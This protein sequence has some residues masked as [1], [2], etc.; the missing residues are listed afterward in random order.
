MLDVR[1]LERRWIKYKIKIYFP[2]IAGV[3]FISVLLI[4]LPII[5]VDTKKVT[6]PKKEPSLPIQTTTQASTATHS[7]EEPSTVLEPSMDF[8]KT[9]ESVVPQ[10]STPSLPNPPAAKP[11]TQNVP[12]TKVLNVPDSSTIKPP[13]KAPPSAV[14][15]PSDKQVTLNHNNESKLDIE[16]VER[17]FKETSNPNLGLF[18][19]RYYYDHGNYADA[20]NFALK[21]N[22]I[23]NKID[24][25]WIIFSKSLMKLGKAEQAKKTL[26]LYIG[27]S[28]S[29]S[30][31][32]LLD[33]IERGT[34]K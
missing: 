3:V 34:F 28:N 16:S 9:F 18:I 30:A 31:R 22:G 19:A 33:S 5:L 32:A 14:V 17:R 27:E 15:S 24:E 8:V 13:L 21:T 11:I 1:N 7:K 20:Y 29:D 6:E 25:S 12:A 2:Y 10:S 4:I 26:Q 23:N